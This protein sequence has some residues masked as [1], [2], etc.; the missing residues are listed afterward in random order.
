MPCRNVIKFNA[1]SNNNVLFSTALRNPDINVNR[2]QFC[3]LI[4]LCGSICVKN[5]SPELQNDLNTL[6]RRMIDMVQGVSV[7]AHL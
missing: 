1:M 2:Q 6:Y 7:Y 4:G 5:E 3:G